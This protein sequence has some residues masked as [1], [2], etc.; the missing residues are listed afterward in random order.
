MEENKQETKKENKTESPT[1]QQLVERAEAAAQR[2]EEANAKQE[3]LMNKQ[4]EARARDILA[5]Q[6]VKQAEPE[7][8]EMSKK[9]YANEILK[10]NLP[11]KN[12]ESQE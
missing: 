2:I 10:G 5:G 3:E 6:S 8:K 4:N 12:E 9:D 11:G 1:T 7:K